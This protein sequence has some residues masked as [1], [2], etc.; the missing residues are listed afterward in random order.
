MTTLGFDK[1][2]YILP[3]DHRGSFQKKLFGWV[4]ELSPEQTTEIAEAKWVIYRA[5]RKAVSAGVPKCKAGILVDEQ[6][7][8]A[9]LHD[10]H[11]EGYSTSCPAEKSG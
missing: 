3:F 11:A 1:P 8:G 2:L 10:A 5:F 6:F 9:I 4:G 7:G